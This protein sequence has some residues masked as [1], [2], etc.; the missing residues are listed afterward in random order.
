VALELHDSIAPM[1]RHRL[2]SGLA[3][4]ALLL[5]G[6]GAVAFANANACWNPAFN[7]PARV[8]ISDISGLIAKTVLHHDPMNDVRRALLVVLRPSGR[9]TLAAA[10]SINDHSPR[11]HRARA[12]P[13][14]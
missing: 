3:L 11:A 14:L 5:L 6:R 4:A 9:V 13:A 1:C 8:D 2:L 7:D 12:P 10:P